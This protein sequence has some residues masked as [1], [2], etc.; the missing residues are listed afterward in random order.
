MTVKVYTFCRLLSFVSICFRIASNFSEGY[1][2]H[3]IYFK[4]FKYR[5][6]LEWEYKFDIY[7]VS[8]NNIARIVVTMASY[9][10]PLYL[11]MSF[12]A[13]ITVLHRVVDCGFE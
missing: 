5:G 8:S 4:M 3:V 7:S 6:F 10:T 11:C 9:F 1:V 2:V 12:Y 13:A